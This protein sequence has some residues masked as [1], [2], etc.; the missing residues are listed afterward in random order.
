LTDDFYRES[1][2]EDNLEEALNLIADIQL[3]FPG[4]PLF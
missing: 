4:N 1:L 2:R 3:E